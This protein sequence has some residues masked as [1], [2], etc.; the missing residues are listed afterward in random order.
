MKQFILNVVKSKERIAL[1]GS[2]INEFIQTNPQYYDVYSVVG[3]YYRHINQPDSS[4]VFYRMALG[5]EIPRQ[6]EKMKIISKLSSCII[7]EKK[8]TK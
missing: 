4:V 1:P 3:D 5:K 2:F 7:K 6:D 8:K